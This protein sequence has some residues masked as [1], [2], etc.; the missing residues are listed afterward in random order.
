[1]VICLFV[2]PCGIRVCIVC[3]E[4]AGSV[5]LCCRDG[6]REALVCFLIGSLFSCCM[7]L[8]VSLCVFMWYTGL[9]SVFKRIEFPSLLLP[10]RW[11]WIASCPWTGSLFC[12]CM[13]LLV[14]VCI[15]VS[16]YNV[17][18]ILWPLLPGQSPWSA[19]CPWTGSL[20]SFNMHTLTCFFVFLFYGFTNLLRV[21]SRD[22]RACT[23]SLQ[24]CDFLQLGRRDGTV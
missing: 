19:S 14:C 5:H 3:L 23:V 21:H 11:P 7:G 4:G 16:L 15:Y 1:M 12:C 17:F 22:T 24:G 10:G 20:F 9:Y 2:C 18:R 6:H 13:G 8:L